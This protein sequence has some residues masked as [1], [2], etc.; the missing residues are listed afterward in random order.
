M[1]LSRLTGGGLKPEERAK[2][3]PNGIDHEVQRHYYDIASIAVNSAAMA[4]VFREFPAS[5][6]L[7]GSDVP[8]WTVERIATAMNKFDLPASDIRAIQRDN[9]LRLLPRLRT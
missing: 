1:V 3:L 4:A 7:F 6:L 5:Q 9:A 2:I 8:F